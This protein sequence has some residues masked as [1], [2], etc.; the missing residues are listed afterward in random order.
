MAFFLIG[1][2]HVQ[3]QDVIIQP[4]VSIAHFDLIVD[5]K[6]S[7][8]MRNLSQ[9]KGEMKNNKF[10]QDWYTA[11]II[12]TLYQI[13]EQSVIREIGLKPLPIESLKGKVNYSPYGY[14]LGSFKKASQSGQSDYYLKVVINIISGSERSKGF[15]IGEDLYSKSKVFIK[16]WVKIRLQMVNQKGEEVLDHLESY[17]SPL[18]MELTERFLF[19]IFHVGSTND[20]NQQREDLAALINKVSGFVLKHAQEKLFP[21]NKTDM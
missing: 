7:D 12:D 6:L 21:Q 15:S 11:R 20:Q 8:Q 13:F 16:P 4:K 18:E 2:S 10:G 3:A 14:P 5:D 1:L 17:R 9:T 19:G